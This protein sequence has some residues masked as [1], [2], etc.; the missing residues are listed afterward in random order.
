MGFSTLC[1]IKVLRSDKDPFFFSV[2]I[3][4]V[5]FTKEIENKSAKHYRFF[6]N[7]LVVE[8]IWYSYR[9]CD[10]NNGKTRQKL[11]ENSALVI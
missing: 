7:Q 3:N 9:V 2:G 6:S 5:F 1:S 11:L 10:D 4:I 8:M